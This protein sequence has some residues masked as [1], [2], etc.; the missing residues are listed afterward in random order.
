MLLLDLVDLTPEDKKAVFKEA[1]RQSRVNLLNAQ[2]IIGPMD[3]RYKD[4]NELIE[5]LEEEIMKK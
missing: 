3:E 4:I 5:W 1:L 2:M